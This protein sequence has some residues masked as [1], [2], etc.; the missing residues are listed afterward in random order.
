MCPLHELKNSS[1]C[2]SP[3]SSSKPSSFHNFT[4][5][6]TQRQINISYFPSHPHSRHYRPSHLEAQQDKKILLTTPTLDPHNTT[7]TP[8]TP[9]IISTENHTKPNRNLLLMIVLVPMNKEVLFGHN[10]QI[11]HNTAMEVKNTFTPN[12]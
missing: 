9:K 11:K 6:P 7:P 5:P 4:T 12:P 2:P 1:K 10:Y 3:S 8:M